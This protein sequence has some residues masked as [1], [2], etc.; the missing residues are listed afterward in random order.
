MTDNDQV[1]EQTQG[2]DSGNDYS[3]RADVSHPAECGGHPTYNA[4]NYYAERNTGGNGGTNYS[5]EYAN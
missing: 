5:D 3:S 4:N 2:S 1:I